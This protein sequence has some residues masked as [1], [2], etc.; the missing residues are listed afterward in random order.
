MKKKHIIITVIASILSLI[1]IC[2]GTIFG[3]WHNEISSLTSIKKIADSNQE[4]KD[5]VT[6]EMTIKG[7]Y[8][9]EDF[10]KQG[11]VKSDGELISFIT[12]NITKG[13]IPI[14]I[15][16]PEIA[17]SSFTAYTNDGDFVFGRNYDFDPTSTAVV[18]TNPGN[19]RYRSIST[20]DLGFIGVDVNGINGLMQRVKTLAAPYMPLDG[21]NE[22]GV[23]CGIYMT[24]Q[25]SDKTVATNQ[26]TDKPDITSTTLLRLILDYA[27]DVN[28]AIEIAKYFDMHDSANTSFHYMVADKKGNSVILEWVG[29]SESTDNDGSKRHLNILKNTKKYQT[30]T[31]FILTDNYYQN[32][33][34]KAGLDRYRLLEKRLADNNGIL[35]TDDEAMKLLSE[36]GRRTF[37]TD[38]NVSK[39]T[40]IHSVVYN[41]TNLTSYFV[42]NENYLKETHQFR[43]SIE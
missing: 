30:V 41:L 17:C 25:G 2:L 18:H 33:N 28:E 39:G 40:T 3:I 14:K 11:G 38:D 5:G 22:K 20:V 26:M 37:V 42:P 8:Y 1:I 43:Y 12:K 21:I 23:A 16:Q 36:V 27:D 24:Y 19:G 4:H 7:D 35:K 34:E 29:E 31:N 10:I 9:L 32:D 13:I 6:Y 15:E